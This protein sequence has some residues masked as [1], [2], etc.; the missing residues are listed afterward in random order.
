MNGAHFTKKLWQERKQGRYSPNVR[1]VMV[2]SLLRKR[3]KHVSECRVDVIA[4][5]HA[6]YNS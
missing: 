6:K 2:R 3:K 5:K 1:F 4:V